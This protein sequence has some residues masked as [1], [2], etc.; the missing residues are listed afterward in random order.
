M[1]H[2]AMNGQCRGIQYRLS[3]ATACTLTVQSVQEKILVLYVFLLRHREEKE[4]V[5]ALTQLSVV[6]VLADIGR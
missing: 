4:Q 6:W 2:G 5:L 1:N 3:M